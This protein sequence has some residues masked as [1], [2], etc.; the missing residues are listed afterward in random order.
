VDDVEPDFPEGRMT[1]HIRWGFIIFL[2]G[3]I[4]VAASS[5]QWLGFFEPLQEEAVIEEGFPGPPTIAAE[6]CAYLEVLNETDPLEADALLAALQ[7]EPVPAP[8]LESELDSLEEDIDIETVSVFTNTRIRTGEFSEIDLLHSAEGVA[9]IWERV[10][11]ERVDR[12]VRLE[13]DFRVVAA[14]PELE[15]Y[16]AVESQPRT[17]DELFAAN[18][19]VRLGLLKG[20]LGGQNYLIAP[21]VDITQYGSVVIYSEALES[22][23]SSAA[24]QQ[25]I[26]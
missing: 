24:L 16:L 1:R 9:N 18:S 6:N 26:N 10:A 7:S 23:I 8:A 15:L 4:A 14:L 11:D 12:F 19:A 2:G 17:P 22:I 3:L 21:D 25:P 13:S 20:H 5:E